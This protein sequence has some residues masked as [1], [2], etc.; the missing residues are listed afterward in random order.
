MGQ[1]VFWERVGYIKR[2][3]IS[4]G[5]SSSS[6]SAQSFQMEPPSNQSYYGSKCLP[7][8]PEEVKVA[9]AEHTLPSGLSISVQ[10]PILG[11]FPSAKAQIGQEGTR[12]SDFHTEVGGNVDLELKL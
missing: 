8:L 4:S 12:G 3:N 6:S 10:Q 2:V 1:V 11:F 7:H 9:T 5:I